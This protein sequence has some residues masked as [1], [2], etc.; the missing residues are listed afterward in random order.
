MSEATRQPRITNEV[1]EERLTNYYERTLEGLSQIRNELSRLNGKV[2]R[3]EERIEVVHDLT[4]GHINAE[5]HP[6]SLSRQ[7]LQEVAIGQL[8]ERQAL[9]TLDERYQ[10]GLAHGKAQA[11]TW[12]DK[13]MIRYVIPLGGLAVAIYTIAKG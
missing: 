5:G 1:L 10:S 7:T 8:R 11:L 3:N 4:A 2:S 6:A 9:Q 13:M 12:V